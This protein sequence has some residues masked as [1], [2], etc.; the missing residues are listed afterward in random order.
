MPFADT[1][2]EI[3]LPPVVTLVEVAIGVALLWLARSKIAQLVAELGVRRVSAVGLE[4]EFT[5]ENA[6]EAY[7]SKGSGRPPR[8]TGQPFAMP[9]STS[10]RSSLNR[11]SSGWTTG[12]AET[13]SNDRDHAQLGG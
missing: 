12:L 4:V 11:E 6:E 2:Y 8:M 5:E 1:W 13:K 9:R 10:C 3:V 7:A